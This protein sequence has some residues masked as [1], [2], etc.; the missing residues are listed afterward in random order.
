M[1]IGQLLFFYNLT[2]STIKGE[3]SEP[4]PWVHL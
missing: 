2:R 1:G 3:P 4:D